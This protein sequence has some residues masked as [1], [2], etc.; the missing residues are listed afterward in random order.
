MAGVARAH[1]YDMLLRHYVAHVTPE[2]Q[3]AAQRIENAAIN[4]LACGENIGVFYGEN[5]E[6]FSAI[7]EVHLAFMNQPRRLTNHRGNI[8]NPIWTHAGVGVVINPQG[9]LI[10]TQK[11]IS[12]P[13]LRA[14]NH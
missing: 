13:F 7:N 4:Y 1:S 11:F 14:R 10:V 5:A 3:T 8:L 9:T 12:S 2:G 6:P